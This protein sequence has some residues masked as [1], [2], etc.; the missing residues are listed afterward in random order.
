MRRFYALCVG[1]VC[2]ADEQIKFFFFA[3]KRRPTVYYTHV[4]HEGGDSLAPAVALRIFLMRKKSH[5][6][7][8]WRLFVV[9]VCYGFEVAGYGIR[10]RN[11]EAPWTVR[12]ELHGSRNLNSGNSSSSNNSNS[13]NSSVI[14]SDSSNYNNSDSNNDSSN[15]N[16]GDNNNDSGNDSSSK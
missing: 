12:A 4:D 6:A 13:N 5:F 15:Y 16:N 10:V 9:V 7:S 3:I 11:V 14:K 8:T 1:R 2:E